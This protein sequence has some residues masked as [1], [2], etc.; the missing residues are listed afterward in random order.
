MSKTKDKLFEEWIEGDHILVHLDARADG[1]AVPSHL[2]DNP[3]LTLKLSYL[4]QGETTTSP[5]GVVSYLRFS[6]EYFRC[7][8]PWDAIWGLSSSEGEQFVWPESI[9]KDLLAEAGKLA[10]APTTQAPPTQAPPTQAPKKPVALA[11]AVKETEDE[12]DLESDSSDSAESP[13]PQSRKPPAL[14]RIK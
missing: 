3:A 2:S 7:F 8:I 4:F 10:L 1:V 5:E 9:P 13:S 6:G 14:T 12:F 11:V